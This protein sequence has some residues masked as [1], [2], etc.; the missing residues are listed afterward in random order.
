MFTIY[1]YYKQML[2]RIP[3]ESIRKVIA[4]KTSTQTRT[5]S[6]DY[7]YSPKGYLEYNFKP[8][9]NWTCVHFTYRSLSF[10]IQI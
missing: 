3:L 4:D 2:R 6:T 8:K 9:C 10:I 5:I 7:N 1:V